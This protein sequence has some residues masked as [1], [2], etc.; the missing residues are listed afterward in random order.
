MRGDFC[1]MG[2]CRDFSK[3]LCEAL[4]VLRGSAFRFVSCQFAWKI[5]SAKFLYCQAALTNDRT[6]CASAEFGMIRHRNGNGA[7]FDRPLHDHVA[8]TLAHFLTGSAF[9][10]QFHRF[11]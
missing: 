3:H 6:Q 8:A 4:T 7:T 10:E 5:E 9:K 11:L 2:I 1:G